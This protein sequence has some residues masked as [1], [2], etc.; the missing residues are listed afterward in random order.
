MQVKQILRI[1]SFRIFLVGQRWE[2]GNF[3]LFG[4]LKFLHTVFA[5]LLK[6]HYD[7]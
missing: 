7:H 2:T 6:V 5:R 1:H 3:D 4:H